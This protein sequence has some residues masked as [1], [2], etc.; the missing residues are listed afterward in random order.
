MFT[1]IVTVILSA[2]VA[3]FLG[4]V[5]FA[6]IFS[7]LFSKKDVRNYGSGNA[8]MTNV[9][10]VSG[11]VPGI[12]TFV[13]D[14]LKGYAAAALGFFAFT[15]AYKHGGSQLF[16][17]LY[18]AYFC[19]LAVIIGHLFPVLFD[20][21]GGKAVSTS[22]GAMLFCNWPSAL[23]ALAVFLIVML[24]TS[25]VSAGSLA[26]AV[27]LTAATPFFPFSTTVPYLMQDCGAVPKAV[28]TVIMGIMAVIIIIKHKDNI[29]RLI[30]GTEKSLFKK[31]K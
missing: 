30:K 27:A 21:R 15:F 3:Y 26:A 7:G 29:D 20:F 17:P 8:G 5:N 11:V 14:A 18:G 28:S 22:F 6:V 31:G 19:S 13:G 23:V 4:S 2:V 1:A 9:M 16:L 24:I 12:L 25:Y 10:R